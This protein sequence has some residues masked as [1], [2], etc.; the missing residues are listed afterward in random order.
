MRTSI[1]TCLL[2]LSSQVRGQRQRRAA[3]VRRAGRLGQGP[4]GSSSRK[5]LS[6][7]SWSVLDSALNATDQS[8]VTLSLRQEHV[9]AACGSRQEERGLPE[10]RRPKTIGAGAGAGAGAVAGAGAGAGAPV[11]GRDEAEGPREQHADEEAGQ[12]HVGEPPP[13]SRLALWQLAL[14]T[15]LVNI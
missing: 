15:P 2:F 13:F 5:P 1:A 3:A 7:A 9:R 4:A 14:L 10:I 12:R 8:R 11:A 6:F